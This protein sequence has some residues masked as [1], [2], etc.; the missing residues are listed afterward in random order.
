MRAAESTAATNPRAS[1]FPGELGL[2]KPDARRAGQRTDA[3]KMGQQVEPVLHHVGGGRKLF[4]RRHRALVQSQR[5]VEQD[6][7]PVL[8]PCA[9]VKKNAR[10]RAA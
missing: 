3:R 7:R 5:M 6:L 8:R 9:F 2:P 10:G 1:P 4:N